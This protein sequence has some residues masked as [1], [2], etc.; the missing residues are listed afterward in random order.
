M[1]FRLEEIHCASGIR[2]VIPPLP[3]RNRHVCGN[4]F[5]GGLK[6]GPVSNFYANV[7]STVQTR[8]IDTNRFTWKQPADC[9][10]FKASLAEPLLLAVHSNSVLSGQIVEW[11]E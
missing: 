9:Q 8:A 10:R 3:K 6:N 1:F 5:R 7:E 2:Q 11:G 4:A